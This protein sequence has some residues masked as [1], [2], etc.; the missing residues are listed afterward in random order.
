MNASP[1]PSL[2][3]VLLVNFIGMLG[4]S[5]IIPL[6]VYLVRDFGGNAFMYGLLGSVYPA[7]QLIGA[8]LLGRWS[9][10]VGRRRILLLSQAGTF[11]AWLL[12]IGALLT[13]P[14]QLLQFPLGPENVF[15]LTLP[16]LLLFVAR[17]FDGLTGGNISVANAY[18]SD[19]STDENRKANFGKMASSTSLGFI[20]G[21]AVASM[22]SGTA[23]GVLLPVMTAA[24][25][26]LIAIAVIYKYLPESRPQAVANNL[27]RLRVKKLFS[28]EIKECYARQNCPDLRFTGILRLPHVSFLYSVYFLTFLGFSF[29]YAGFPI[30]ASGQ[31]NWPPA[32]LGTFFTVSSLVMVVFQGP[33]LTYLSSRVSDALLVSVGSVLIAA[34]FFLLTLG[35][36]EWVFSAVVLMAMGNGLMWP[37][38][39][40]I[41]SRSGT[42]GIQGTIQG[43]ANSVGSAASILGLVLGGW[44]MGRLGPV[45]FW[46]SGTLFV[47][48]FLVSFYLSRVENQLRA[49]PAVG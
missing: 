48:I 43:Y 49:T 41:L 5:I 10:Q 45:V 20:I 40:A 32:R 34:N 2:F 24:L 16:L 26:S 27:P 46:V 38:F 6:L 3:P 15:L 22:L 12:F 4:Y 11:L 36:D 44:L 8:P 13:P 21:P 37:S 25:V 17:A 39:L 23:L 9:D 33:V 28:V 29:F 19:V 42:P 7:F 31:L 47:L 18:L 1:K 30:Y 35:T 14:R